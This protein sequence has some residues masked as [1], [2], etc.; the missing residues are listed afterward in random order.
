MAATTTS[1]HPHN[2]HF[3][4]P[5]HPS[6]PR[7][8]NMSSP[9]RIEQ[10]RPAATPTV[11]DKTVDTA[12]VSTPTKDD[13]GGVPGQRPLPTTPFSPSD[14]AN[15]PDADKSDN[16]A[17]TTRSGQQKEDSED[18]EMADDG[19]MDSENDS[20]ASDSK[21]RKK[22]KG[23]RFFCTD[24]PPCNLSFTR[25]EH[26]ARHIRKHTG[27]RPFQCHCSRRFSRLDNL[28]Q[29]AQTVHVNEEIPGDSLAATSSRFQRQIRTDRVR[30]PGGRAR[31]GTGGS[32]GH[33]RG[34]SRNLSSSS[35]ASTTSNVSNMPDD[36]RRRP[37]P[38]AM[39]SQITPGRMTVDP[40]AQP[41]AA[42]T[43][44]AYYTAQS[45]SGY[46]TPTSATFSTGG[47][48]PRFPVQSPS[49]AP[50]AAYYP[51]SSATS[52]R[53]LSVPS[54]ASPY[55]SGH[56]NAYPPAHYSPY[57]PAGGFHHSTA[58]TSSIHSP[59]S[60]VYSHSRRDSDADLEWRRRTWH[61]GTYAAHVQRPATSGLTYAQ[62]PDDARPTTAGQ[63]AASQVTRLPGIESFDHAIS[64]APAAARSSS[65]MQIDNSGRPPVY[66][67]PMEGKAPGPDDRRSNSVW[68]ASLHQNLNRL[69]ITN[70]TPPR[71][72]VARARAPLPTFH[73]P[74]APPTSEGGQN[75]P[76]ASIE[77]GNEN[78]GVSNRRQGW[79][80]GP[81]SRSQPI[82]IAHRPS[83]EESGSSDGVPTPSTSQGTEAHPA[84]VQANGMVV[85]PPGAALT[86]EQHRAMEAERAKPEPVRTDS[87]S[88]MYAHYP[89]GSH[90]ASYT[91]HSGHDA[92]LQHHYAQ[93]PPPRNDMG[94]LEAL[95][96]V[97]TSEN[98]HR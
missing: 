17:V 43:Q 49:I 29:H 26:L 75:Q 64:A 65:P 84:I 90:G 85:R 15:T 20:N 33:V 9:K 73:F 4:P 8:M 78:L 39:A 11:D 59:T 62:T 63:S 5:T 67:G 10:S 22:K 19:E 58:S 23:Q 87:G 40:Y 18:V 32:I 44:Y 55:Q 27:E 2:S 83:P 50:R 61:P 70:T 25:S 12:E 1:Y 13:F 77:S 79:Y 48:S 69:D 41:G 38:L 46:S 36:G 60:S 42:P 66:L 53:R 47:N 30:A 81:A 96:A 21:P 54:V 16:D 86:E 91:L 89:H 72:A 98:A 34:H 7:L 51:P 28:R 6:T 68:E 35:I 24:F 95:V 57:P 45:P 74:Q 31:A 97:A 88:H 94:R 82:N 3:S 76:T 52:A 56:A 37:P 93:H 71:P 14:I 80:G 92:R